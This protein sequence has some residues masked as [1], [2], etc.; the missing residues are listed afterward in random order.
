MPLCLGDDDWIEIPGCQYRMGLEDDEIDRLAEL[1]ASVARRRF[2]EI[3]DELP[4]E[5]DIEHLHAV[6]QMAVLVREQLEWACDPERVREILKLRC[7]AYDVE[8]PAFA[9][10]RR[11]VTNAMFDQFLAER[12]GAPP[13]S[14]PGERRDADAAVRG[15]SWARA[16]EFAEWAGARLPFEAEWERAARGLERRLFPWGNDL[17]GLG[18]WRGG[19]RSARFVA[20]ALERTATPDGIIGLV[21]GHVAHRE[22]CADVRPDPNLP[23]DRRGERESAWG[24]ATRGGSVDWRFGG[25]TLT[26]DDFHYLGELALPHV[27]PCAASRTCDL[28]VSDD[29]GASPY[30]QS[31]GFRIVRADGRTMPTMPELGPWQSVAPHVI[32][33]ESRVVRPVLED[34]RSL[35]G[36]HKTYV[37][38]AK[39]ADSI[40][41]QLDPKPY[42]HPAWDLIGRTWDASSHIS[43]L[44]ALYPDRLLGGDALLA[45]SLETFRRVIPDHGLF[46]WQV[47]YRLGPGATTIYAHPLAVFR[48]AFDGKV[49]VFHGRFAPS[50]RDTAIER[51]TP[52]MVAHSIREFFDYYE[53]NSDK[54]RPVPPP[55]TWIETEQGRGMRWYQQWWTARAP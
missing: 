3:E 5:E 24:R 11:P 38:D 9:I 45:V 48:M 7:F 2:E 40:A 55:S 28:A 4:R 18:Y 16:V 54:D 43:E 26:W 13:A 39:N 20:P 49:H 50:E 33:F 42:P 31:I 47:K 52:E 17:S 30:F 44:D 35:L 15:V 37:L 32:A 21:S 34:V 23:Y 1:S 14:E 36:L 8:V 51:I 6:D 41:R 22:W 29:R 46:V 27:I 19:R 25:G 12:G 10:S 53:E